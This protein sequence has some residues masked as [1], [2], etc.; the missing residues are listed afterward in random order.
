MGQNPVQKNENCPIGAVKINSMRQNGEENA[1][2]SPIERRY[3]TK[4]SAKE[5]KLSHR[6]SQNKFYET[7]WKE[8]SEKLSHRTAL[9]DKT[10]CKR[11][12]TV[13]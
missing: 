10:Q 6:S 1:K 12:K 7:K 9:W 4:P 11:K 2:N 8:K 13:S 3:G 5:R